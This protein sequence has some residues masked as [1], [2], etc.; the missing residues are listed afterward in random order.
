M[1]NDYFECECSSK[2]HTFCVSSEESS[3]QMPPELYFHVQL[4]QPKNLF[5]KLSTALKYIF[6]YQ[7]KFGHWDTI[8]IS[9]DDASRLIVLLHQ[10]RARLSKFRQSPA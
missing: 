4:I 7:C 8:N 9:E 3:D 6:G 5:G 2:E 1:N 10:H